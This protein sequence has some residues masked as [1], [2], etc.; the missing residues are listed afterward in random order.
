M[1]KN[2]LYILAVGAILFSSCESQLDVAPAGSQVSD[3]QLSELMS[4]DPEAG[5]DAM[6]RGALYFAHAGSR[7]GNTDGIGLNVWNLHMDLQGNDM[8]I[9]DLTN[10]FADSY[11]FENLRLQ[12]SSLAADLWYNYY[13]LIF[14]SNQILDRVALVP[15]HLYTDVVDGYKAGALTYRALGYYYLLSIFRDDYMNGGKTADKGLPFYRSVG[16]ALPCEKASTMYTEL[17]KDLQNAIA[18][19]G[20]I[21]YDPTSST[22][23]MDQTVANIVLARIAMNAGQYAVAAKAAGDVIASNAYT[24]MTP[25]EYAAPTQ[26]NPSGKAWL[27]VNQPETIWGYTWAEATSNGNTSFNTWVCP[28]LLYYGY[29]NNQEIYMCMS[30][31]LYAQIP[32]TDC[33]KACIDPSMAAYGFP[34]TTSWKFAINLDTQ[35]GY[36]SDNIYMRLAEAYLLKAEA[37]ARG[38]DYTAAQQTLF[39]LVSKRDSGYTKSTKT[40]DELLAEIH[41]Q[42]RIELWGE[43][44][45]WFT[46]KRFNVGVDRTNSQLHSVP[47]KYE[48]GSKEFTYQIPLT[49]EMTPNPHMTDADQNPA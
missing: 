34:A 10:W 12:T 45:E 22:D 27:D 19:Y 20:K 44:H 17:I 29:G 33:R 46:N 41:L 25:M 1:K 36:D 24:L 3:E 4:K 7:S 49:S 40:G 31:E 37:E 11:M 16:D 6:M 38:T 2:L 35:E 18:I 13:Q 47:A 5:L 30:D 9:S 23:D 8:F 21:G 28:W 32:D 26:A 42:S 43:G 39:D 14:L 48:A 15:E